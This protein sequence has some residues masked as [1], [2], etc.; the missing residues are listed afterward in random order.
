VTGG[1]VY[2]GCRLKNYVGTYFYGDYCAAFVRTFVMSGGVATAQTDITNQVNPAGAFSEISSF[3]VDG[4]GELYIVSLGGSVRK[5]VPPFSDMEVSAHGAADQL[6]LSK[7][8]DWTWENIFQT[9]DILVNYYRVYRGSVNGTYTCVSKPTAAKW[10]LGGD[11]VNPVPGRLF[12]Y[13]VTAVNFLGNETLYGTTGTFN[14]STC[15]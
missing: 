15:P 8:G 6:R 7:T 1:Y 3:G 2:R 10:P 11:P 4:L 5:I 13:V 12:T 14:A 9:D